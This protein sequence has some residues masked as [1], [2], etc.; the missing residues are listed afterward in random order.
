MHEYWSHSQIEINLYS[1]F[2]G[3]TQLWNQSKHILFSPST[4]TV[5]KFI[6]QSS[7]IKS[8]YLPFALGL[9]IIKYVFE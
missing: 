8:Y 4:N 2:D 5:S 6:F 1:F 3:K 7:Y 9:N